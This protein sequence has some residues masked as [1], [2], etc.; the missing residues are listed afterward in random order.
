MILL[1]TV[2]PVT[3]FILVLD[4]LCRSSQTELLTACTSMS[5]EGLKEVKLPEGVT[6]KD[7][8]H[9]APYNAYNPQ[10]NQVD[11]IF[12]NATG[13]LLHCCDRRSTAMPSTTNS[14]GKLTPFHVNIVACSRICRCAG[15]HGEDAKE[16][17]KIKHHFL[18][19][20]PVEWVRR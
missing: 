11:S 20:C 3:V 12:L 5:V 16:C 9:T 10:Q 13:F 19:L 8:L 2:D 17:K 4:N 14:S 6:A 7:I 15:V 1:N 18:A